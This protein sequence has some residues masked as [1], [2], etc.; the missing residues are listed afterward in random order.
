MAGETSENTEDPFTFMVKSFTER[1]KELK[2]LML[3][4]TPGTL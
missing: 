1:I 2:A 4:R 3:M